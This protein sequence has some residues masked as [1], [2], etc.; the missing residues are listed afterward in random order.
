MASSHMPDDDPEQEKHYAHKA[1]AMKLP[2]AFAAIFSLNRPV[3]RMP[4]PLAQRFSTELTVFAR[5]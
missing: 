4:H 3:T 1:G 5:R 2:T